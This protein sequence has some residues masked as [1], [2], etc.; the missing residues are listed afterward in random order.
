MSSSAKKVFTF[1]LQLLLSKESQCKDTVSCIAEF[2]GKLPRRAYMA[3]GDLWLHLRDN[4]PLDADI[5]AANGND[6]ITRMETGQPRAVTNEVV[7]GKKCRINLF[8]DNDDPANGW[9][10]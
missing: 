3:N 1:H 4:Q 5:D 6:S 2:Q 7:T 9:V 8:R 10:N